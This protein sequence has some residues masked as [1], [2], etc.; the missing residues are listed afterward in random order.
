MKKGTYI[1]LIDC[2]NFFVSCE[3]IFRPDLRKK[4]VAVLSNNDG[5]VVARSNEVK[6]LGIPMGVPYFQIK[7]KLEREGAAVFSGNFALYG[8]IS[9]RIMTIIEKSVDEIEI[10]SIDE[11]FVELQA[12]ETRSYE[13]ASKIK[14]AIEIGTGVPV[15]VGIAQT[16]TLAKLAGEYAKKNPENK[17]IYMINESNRDAILKENEISEIWGVG[18]QTSI[19]L[20]TY[21]VTT[22]KS[23]TKSSDQWIRAT[24]GLGGL[25]I[26]REL[27]GEKTL[28]REILAKGKK[29][30]LSSRSFGKKTSERRDLEEAVAT[31]VTNA[32]RK[33]RREGCGAGFIS[34]F[35]RS[36]RRGTTRGTTSSGFRALVSPTTDTLELIDHA[37]AILSELDKDNVTYEK[38]GV[39][40]SNIT[41][42]EYIPTASLFATLESTNREKLMKTIDS[43]EKKYG[44]NI[45]FSGATGITGKQKWLHKAQ[46]SSKGSTT[47]WSSLPVVKTG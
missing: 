42:A 14:R 33:M 31:H 29:S 26:V 47:E 45:V 41:P 25:R 39:L 6:A 40:L 28:I 2:N 7:E 30:I 37:H 23:F 44:N 38:A 21:G 5:C 36:A 24:L 22:A 32:A 46:F 35:I 17:G 43:L 34:V 15:S 19:K 1:A 13:Q 12:D 3:R 9:R 20:R 16:K 11:A 10:Y 8:D 4:P 18:G 27:R